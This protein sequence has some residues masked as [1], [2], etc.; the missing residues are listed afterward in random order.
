[1]HAFDYHRPNS[2]AEAAQ[3]LSQKPEAS[4]LAGGQTL[5]P[6]L[7]QRL[8]A[9][10]E[11]IDLR[12]ITELRRVEKSGSNIVV[13]AMA[14]H[15]QVASNAEV[16]R[17]IPALAQLAGGIGDPQVRHAGTIAGSIANNDPAADYPAAVLGLGATVVTNKGK[18]DA[19]SFF[20]GLFSTALEPGEIITEVSFPIPSKSGYAK[21][22]QRASRYALVGVFVA[23]FSG[24]FSTSVRAAVTGAGADGV[25]RSSELEQALKSNW[26]ADAVRDLK[27]PDSGLLS[28]LHASAEYRAA[29]IPVMAER[30]VA[31]TG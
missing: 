27:L 22:E 19:D 21:F 1:M 13:G 8:A 10:S 30:A 18:I 6:T 7:K 5:I 28:D 9:P 26:S 29:L 12:E 25:F 3:I 16:Q 31:N 11:V 2:V 4:L 14:T 15:A 20:T 23:Q 17:S 24:M